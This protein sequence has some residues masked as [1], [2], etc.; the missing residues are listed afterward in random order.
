[1]TMPEL[2]KLVRNLSSMGH[3]GVEF[4]VCNPGNIDIDFEKILSIL[5]EICYNSY[6]SIECNPRR[7]R[8]N[9]AEIKEYKEIMATESKN[10]LNLFTLKGKVALDTCGS[11][12][13][14]D[15][16]MRLIL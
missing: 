16:D 2:E 11:G 3:D 8:P 5:E 6:V 4:K 10:I 12:K 7:P 13:C 15:V 9:L 1:M 14:Q